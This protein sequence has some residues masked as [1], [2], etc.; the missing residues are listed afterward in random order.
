LQ[1]IVSLSWREDFEDDPA[2]PA[3]EVDPIVTN[4]VIRLSEVINKVDRYIL[5][6]G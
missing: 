6:E 4:V 1:P 3:E 5:G 2:F